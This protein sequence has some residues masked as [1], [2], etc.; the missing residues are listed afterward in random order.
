MWGLTT[1]TAHAAG[2]LKGLP[3]KQDTS[4][5]R[6]ASDLVGTDAPKRLYAARVLRRR[7]RTAWRLAVR[8]GTDMHVLE[9][10]QTLSEF[11]SLIAPRCIRQL[12]VPATLRPCAQ[13]L[14]LLETRSALPFLKDQ[15]ER[16][17]GWITRR[18]IG[19]AI[20]RIEAA[21]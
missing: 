17:D 5:L 6:Y 13:I 20:G 19:K 18:I 2:P 1:T 21:Q 10:R 11:D 12:D 15:R 4:T 7:V 16:A 3:V 8:D 14:G 9:A